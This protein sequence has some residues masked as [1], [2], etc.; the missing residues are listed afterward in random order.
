MLFW[1]VQHSPPL[2]G[3][4]TPTHADNVFL[5]SNKTSFSES[6]T[7]LTTQRSEWTTKK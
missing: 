7:E 4:D 3:A 1:W 6:K 5:R 2:P